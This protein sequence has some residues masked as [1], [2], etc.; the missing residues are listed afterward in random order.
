MLEIIKND[1]M[2]HQLQQIMKKCLDITE[3]W[4]DEINH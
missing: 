1:K 4:Q 2:A 3:E